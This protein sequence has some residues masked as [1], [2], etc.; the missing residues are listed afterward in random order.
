MLPGL[1]AGRADFDDD[2]SVVC[3]LL[4]EALF[5]AEVAADDGEVAVG[6]VHV[7]S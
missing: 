4:A 2:F 7:T 1:L 6:L 3:E 5:I